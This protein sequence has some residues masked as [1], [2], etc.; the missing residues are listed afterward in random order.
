MSTALATEPGSSSAPDRSRRSSTPTTASCCTGAAAAAPA[1]CSSPAARTAPD[2][3]P[4]FQ[5]VRADASGA[6][7]CARAR[8]ETRPR[9]GTATGPPAGCASPPGSRGSSRRCRPSCSRR[10]A[11]APAEAVLDVGCGTGPTTRDAAAAVGPTGRVTGLDV[12]QD[13]LD[14]GRR[15]AGRRPAP[16]RI[17]WLLADASHVVAARPPALRRRALPLRRDVL[18]RPGRGVRQPRPAP[19]AGRPPRPRRVGPA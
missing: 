12:S 5:R 19:P 4:R 17:D 2:R 14:R 1:A 8:S 16:R 10:P 7:V 13:M 11:L 6:M 18:L 3:G 15:R 9:P